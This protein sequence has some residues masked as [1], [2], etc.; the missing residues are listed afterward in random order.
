MEAESPA[1]QQTVLVVDDE[2]FVRE[3]C[4]EII[5]A[6]GYHVLAAEDA[7]EGLR[8]A[9]EEPVGAILL[10]LMMPRMSGFDALQIFSKDLPDIPVVVMTAH[11]SQSR[12]IDLLKL[13]AYDFVP[14]PF[15]PDD[16]VY[17]VRRALER[18]RL[19]TENKR[20]VRELQ[21]RVAELTA[22]QARTQEL[23][24]ALQDQV[25]AQTL[26][27]SRGRQ[28]TENIISHMGS[29]LLVT[30]R[31]GRIWMIN[32]HGQETLGVTAGGVVGQRLLELFPDA[33][34][35]LDVQVGSVLRELDLKCPGGQTVP[36]GFNNSLLLDAAGQ[37]EGTIVI[38]RDLSDLRAIRAEVRRKDRLAAI[39]EV[40]AGVAHEIRNPLFGISSVAQILMTEVKFDPVHQE[41]L[42]AMQSE[43]KRLNSLVEDL[44]NY[45]RPA[46]LQRAPQLLEQIWE[47]ILGL[48]KEELAGAKVHIAREIAGGVPPVLA[49]G[50]QLRQVF[51]NLLKNAIQATP[52]GGRITIRVHRVR[53]S[54]L[55]APVQRSLTLLAGDGD[56]SREYVASAVTDTGVGIPAADLDRV[57]DLFF[58]TKSTGSGLGLAICRR[59]VEDH[60]GAIGVESAEQAGSTFTIALPLQTGS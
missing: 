55:P 53:R 7:D 13:G 8:L 39:G 21:A 19:L 57:F 44:L 42:A 38:F 28:L 30:D 25:Q 27:L 40:A 16:L 15:E 52:P 23:A 59:I 2:R 14:K 12:I 5:A 18:H 11:S 9:R 26:E 58:T 46:N 41:L 6:E 22:A 43:I 33:G 56:P 10:D 35:L 4:A 60:G 32:Q 3:L 31:D 49:D 47:E 37:P 29:G 24:R 20:L 17:S 45:G 34:P 51:L 54:A 1:A 36:L 48:A 50:N